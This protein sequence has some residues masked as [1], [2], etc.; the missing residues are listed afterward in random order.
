MFIIKFP[1]RIIN[2][3][4]KNMNLMIILINKEIINNMFNKKLS[5]RI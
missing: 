4:N 5:M 2:K 3:M 1:C